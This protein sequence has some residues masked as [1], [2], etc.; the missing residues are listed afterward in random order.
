MLLFYTDF[1]GE[2][3]FQG[4]PKAPHN[5]DE[6]QKYN[7][8]V[9]MGCWGMC[10]YAFSAAFYSAV[11]E[12]LEERFSTRT[13]YFVAYLAFGLGTGLATLSR[14]VYVLLS[15]C[16]TYGILF[17]TL[18]TLPYSLLC[19][20]YQSREVSPGLGGAGSPGHPSVC[21]GTPPDSVPVFPRTPL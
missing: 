19:D 9:T 7:T 13:L 21:P 11:L 16:A 18:C 3:V 14:N 8:G 6:Y 12:K 4:D 10:I 15:L 20:Y 17:A 5:S 1:M 2:V